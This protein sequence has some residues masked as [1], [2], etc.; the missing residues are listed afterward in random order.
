MLEFLPVFVLT[1]L[2]FVVLV[3][4]IGFGRA[5]TYRPQRQ[6]VRALIAGVLDRTTS[7]DAWGMFIGLP[8][9]HD[10]P[11]EEIRR[12]CVEIHEGLDGEPAASEGINGYLYDRSGRERLAAVLAQLDELIRHTP[13]YR[14]F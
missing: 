5:P 14:S 10:P 8:I 3:G 12:R 4:L 11:L 2:L 6:E 13:V 1:L 7:A 9:L